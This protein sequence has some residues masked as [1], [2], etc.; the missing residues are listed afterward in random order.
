M[1]DTEHA[2]DGVHEPEPSTD[3]EAP[4]PQGVTNEPRG[5][6]DLDEDALRKGEERL[7]QAAG[8]N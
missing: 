3:E 1:T 6:G 8:S 2:G 5:T 7:D 4:A